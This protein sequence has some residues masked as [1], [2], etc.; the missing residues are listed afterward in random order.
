MSVCAITGTVKTAAGVAVQYAYVRLRML[1]PPVS[2]GSIAMQTAPV[3]NWT[4]SDGT[5]TVTATQGATAR[6][7]IPSCQVDIYGTVP[8]SATETLENI[9]ASW[10]NWEP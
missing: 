3:D 6:L 10:E 8:A 2:S 1:V 9:L 5:V 4:A 7:E